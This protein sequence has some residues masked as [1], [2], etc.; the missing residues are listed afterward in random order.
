MPKA[1][2]QDIASIGDLL[3]NDHY[4]FIVGAPRGLAA[5]EKLHF[6]C[7]DVAFPGVHNEP[8]VVNLFG[9]QV[10]HRGRKQ[11]SQQLQVSYAVDANFDSTRYLRAWHELVVGADSGNSAGTKA[12][13]CAG[14]ILRIFDSKGKNITS[15]K[16]VNVFPEEVADIQFSSNGTQLAVVQATFAYDYTSSDSVELGHNPGDTLEKTRNSK[17]SAT[18]LI[19]QFGSGTKSKPADSLSKLLKRF[20]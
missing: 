18:N 7:M 20:T 16:F 5:D 17:F 1:T 13:Y 8:I 2:L 9:H 12:D 15:L 10:K 6:K 19:R 4:E 11:S 3:S 14:A